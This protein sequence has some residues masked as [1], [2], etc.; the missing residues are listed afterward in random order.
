VSSGW[1]LLPALLAW[2]L[3]SCA[4]PPLAPLA[5]PADGRIGVLALDRT[6]EVNIEGFSGGRIQGFASGM[7][8]TFVA[9]F[10]AFGQGACM[11]S[12]CGAM[13]LF[14]LGTCGTLSVVGGLASALDTDADVG[15]RAAADSIDRALNTAP[16]Q[17]QLRDRI[18]AEA[19][20]RGTTLAAL[21][22]PPA[23]R[24]E[25]DYRAIRGLGIDSVLEVELTRVGTA[26]PGGNAPSR[27]YMEAR[28]RLVRVGDRVEL[29][30][31]QYRVQGP[32]YSAWEWR[33]NRGSLLLDGF[34]KAYG[35]L[36][37]RICDAH[38]R[39]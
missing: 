17:L 39:P 15:K 32:S 37:E 26:G 38:F 5:S 36:A 25:V 4:T 19:Q 16:A 28:A 10:Q 34:Q 12:G 8:N 9:C 1:R 20:R 11:N 22:L 29:A 6:P 14:L 33:A 23:S 27:L 13:V 24:G 35:G 21:D 31:G 30:R 7:E 18:V 2:L 3:A